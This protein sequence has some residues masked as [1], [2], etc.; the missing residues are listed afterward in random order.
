MPARPDQ[1]GNAAKSR[2][3]SRRH[4]TRRAVL[5][6]SVSALASAAL[7]RSARAQTGAAATRRIPATGE[8]IPAVGLGTW[9]TFNVGNDPVLRDECV[10]VMASF[11]TAGGRIID[12]SP[13]YGSSQEVIGYGLARIGAPRSLF[14]ADK[15]WTSSV[16]DGPMQI[17]TSRRNWS[18]PRFDLLQVHNLVGWQHHLP[19][20]LEMKQ[21]GKLR[22][23]GITTSE[24]RRHDVF[25]EIMRSQPLD[26]VQVTYNV[27]D[28]EV[29]RRILPLAQDRGIGVIVN[30]PFRQGALTERLAAE[31]LP[32]WA[33]EIGASS[34]AQLILKF[35]LSHPAVTVAIP[36]TTRTDHAAENVAAASGPVPDDALRERIAAH[37][38]NL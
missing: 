36:A 17:E 33:D 38:R 7:P 23:V 22:Y 9:I 27:L 29:E 14:S 13:M 11:F 28:R 34:W 35:I 5:A 2:A 18:L 3:V 37:V 10:A 26:F 25:E 21:A 15:V 19:L 24:G 31:P 6:A 30:R 1:K 32:E 4:P 16:S 20:L 8:E 12:S